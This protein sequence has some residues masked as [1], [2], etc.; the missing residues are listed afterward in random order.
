MRI[1]GQMRE[2]MKRSLMI[3]N[4]RWDGIGTEWKTLRVVS[5]S[6]VGSC[7]KNLSDNTWSGK[8]TMPLYADSTVTS[9]EP[10]FSPNID[11]VMDIQE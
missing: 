1:D 9:D 8:T 7:N 11:E 10:V 4:I 3:A 5:W 6:V 2:L